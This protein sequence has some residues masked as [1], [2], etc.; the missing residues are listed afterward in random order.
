MY[1]KAKV[2]KVDDL[3]LLKCLIEGRNYTEPSMILLHFV[4]FCICREQ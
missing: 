3:H 2:V 1:Q 4:T